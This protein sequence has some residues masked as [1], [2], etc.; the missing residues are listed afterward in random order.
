MIKCPEDFKGEYRIPNGVTSIEDYAFCDCSD[1]TSITISDSV[2]SIDRNAF[3]YCKGLKNIIIPNSVI[4]IG[5]HA[6]SW[7]EKLESVTLSSNIKEIIDYA[8]YECRNLETI[9]IPNGVTCIGAYA[10]YHCCNLKS[11]IIPRSV[12]TIGEGAFDCTGLTSIIIPD[13]VTSIEDR[14]FESTN[15]TSITI[16]NSVT[17]IG[18]WCFCGCKNLHTIY[19][20]KGYST[21][22]DNI[23]TYGNHAKIE[24]QRGV[25]PNIINIQKYFQEFIIFFDTETT[26]LLS[27]NDI[28]TYEYYEW[29][30]LVQLAWI[31]TDQ[32]GSVIRQKSKIVKPL[33][34]VIPS[35]ATALH[36]ITNER[37]LREGRP[38]RE[39]LDDFITDLS[40]AEQ[41]VGH[42]I[43]FDEKVIES[44]ID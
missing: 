11:V 22:S 2:T 31:L 34:F 17:N 26:G 30:R 35:E 8:F 19:I 4:S 20:P 24:E 44:E 5:Y 21:V 23:L 7:C 38:L 3:S 36:G 1:L 12:T 43:V 25:K 39:I 16:P 37:A 13:S 15:L 28:P 33:D 40:C 27:P 29:P 10:F 42:Y 9:I 32:T 14:A 41:I 6:F 18:E